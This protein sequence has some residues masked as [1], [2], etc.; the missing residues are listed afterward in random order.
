MAFCR[1]CF[2]R[3]PTDVRKQMRDARDARAPHLT[4]R[5]VEA[6][7]AWLREHPLTPAGRGAAS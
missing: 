5:A 2:N 7:M 6:A 3:L 1:T 4:A